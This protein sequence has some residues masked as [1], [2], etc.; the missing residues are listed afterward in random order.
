[1]Q[2]TSAKTGEQA[3][4]IGLWQATPGTKV[5]LPFLTHFADLSS[6]ELGQKLMKVMPT[7][8]ASGVQ[9]IV[10]GLGSAT[11][12]R[13]FCRV[14]R[15]PIDNLYCDPDGI[16]YKALNFSPGFGPGLQISPYAKLLPM[17][18]GIGSPGT[19]QEVFRGYVGDKESKPVFDSPT[20]FDILGAGYQRPFE[21]AT[22]RLFNMIGIIPKWSELSP[23]R[24][25]LLTQQG[26]ALAFAGEDTIFRH[27]DSGI[28]KYT[29]V[30]ALL[31]AVLA[32][33]EVY[34][35]TAVTVDYNPRQDA[36][37]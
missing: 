8:E 35:T 7:L 13:E 29:D 34:N 11:N 30:D 36:Q 14:L 9:V 31:R 37:Q 24:Q 3:S 22:L 33:E 10:V 20:P 23:S 28:L 17:L 1:M 16:A 27:D 12:A 32:A 5:V 26:G 4:L 25:D 15:F 2:V 19:I 21:L 6:W 18:M